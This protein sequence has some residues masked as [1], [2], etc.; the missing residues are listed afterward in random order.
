ML[1]GERAVAVPLMVV[2]GWLVE[3]EPG[4]LAVL[5]LALLV[6]LGGVLLVVF[7]V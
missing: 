2:L 6:V 1:V 3:L 7:T 4:V 5:E